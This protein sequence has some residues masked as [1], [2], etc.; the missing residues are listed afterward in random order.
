MRASWAGRRTRR[1]GRRWRS[2]RAGCR[3]REVSRN[4]QPA[5]AAERAQD[6]LVL[7]AELGLRVRVAQ[8]VQHRDVLAVREPDLAQLAWLRLL[9]RRGRTS[10]CA[11]AG[12]RA[13]PPRSRRTST[14]TSSRTRPSGTDSDRRPCVDCAPGDP[15]R[16]RLAGHADER[17]DQRLLG[18]HDRVVDR[19]VA[20]EGRPASHA[21]SFWAIARTELIRRPTAAGGPARARRPARRR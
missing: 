18:R 21:R 10:S 6:V 12:A 9:W 1:R 15:P 2:R 17:D 19:V 20:R 3:S 8:L 14:A 5:S 16:A 7:A 4:I 13:G 11:R